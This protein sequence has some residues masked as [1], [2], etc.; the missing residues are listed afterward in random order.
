MAGI[1]FLPSALKGYWPISAA[2]GVSLAGSVADQV[3]HEG[4]SPLLFRYGIGTAVGL[5]LVFIVAPL[6][7]LRRPLRRARGR[8]RSE[9]GSLASRFD[10]QFE[11]KWLNGQAVVDE[12]VLQVQDFSAMADLH[13]VASSASRMSTLPFSTKNLIE[14][15]LPALIPFLPLAFAIFPPQEVFDQLKKLTSFVL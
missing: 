10:R 3:L 7:T 1:R 9:Y 2:L 5:L 13:Q 12:G 14:T 4:A 15:L 8:G 6:M 11:E